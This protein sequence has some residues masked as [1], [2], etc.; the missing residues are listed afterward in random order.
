MPIIRNVTINWLNA[1]PKAGRRFQNNPDAPEKWDVQLQT[2]DKKEAN[3]WKAEYGFKIRTE[4]LDDRIVYR[5]TLGAYT[6]DTNG[7]LNKPIVVI[8]ADGTSVDPGI[9]GNGSIAN[10]SFTVSGKA[11]DKK[12]R[13]KGVQL[14]KLIKREDDTE[15]ELSDDY[16]IIEDEDLASNNN[17]K[18]DG[19]M[20][21]DQY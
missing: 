7:E 20:A 10:I 21:D 5:T 11:G 4:E 1:N 16:E 8:L 6:R 17:N 2:F 15:F 3:N 18:E 14:T 9:V 13:F 19:N 12:R